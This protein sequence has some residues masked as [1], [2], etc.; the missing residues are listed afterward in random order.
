[1]RN[2]QSEVTR[3]VSVRAIINLSSD[4]A[5]RKL[6]GE[7]GACEVLY[8]S[9]KSFPGNVTIVHGA[10]VACLSL[11]NVPANK[12]KLVALGLRAILEDIIKKTPPDGILFRLANLL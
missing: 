1:M 4:T 9:I 10:S 2:T 6:L 3:D 11:S 5:N 7:A 12:Q 8:E